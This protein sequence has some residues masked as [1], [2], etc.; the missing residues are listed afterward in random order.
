[1]LLFSLGPVQSFIAQD[2]KTRDLWLGSLLLSALMQAGMQDVKDKLIFPFDPTIRKHI[3]DLPNKY[4]AV[5][6][7]LA[8]AELA[9]K[10]SEK[11]V[12][13]TW[14]A[15]SDEVWNEVL[16]KVRAV[17][18][19]T[20]RQWKVQVD[21]VNLFEFYWVVLAGDDQHYKKWTDGD[22]AVR[23]TVYITAIGQPQTLKVAEKIKEV[24]EIA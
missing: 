1:M 19:V 2:R 7:T 21:P 9:A 8:E 18:A 23:L 10:Q 17:D 4:I 15:I 11:Y 16:G 14:N 6:S 5:F 22:K 20:R 3:P 24:L 13:S 12:A